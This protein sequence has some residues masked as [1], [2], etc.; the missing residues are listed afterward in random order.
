MAK[1]QA[2]TPSDAGEDVEQQVRSFIAGGDAEWCSH[3]VW[4]YNDGYKSLYISPNP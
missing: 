2:L 3:A 4:C 1:T